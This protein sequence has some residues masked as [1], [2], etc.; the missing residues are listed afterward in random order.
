MRHPGRSSVPVRPPCYRDRAPNPQ[1]WNGPPAFPDLGAAP[2]CGVAA[3]R[4]M[5]RPRRWPGSVP[6]RQPLSTGAVLSLPP[7]PPC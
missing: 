4:S 3:G 5:L 1:W 6:D 7:V 2:P